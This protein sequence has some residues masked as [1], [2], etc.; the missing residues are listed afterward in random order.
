[1]RMSDFDNWSCWS[2][3]GA[4]TFK[5][6]Q[7]TNTPNDQYPLRKKRGA[8]TAPQRVHFLVHRT[9]PS[10]PKRSR[11]L[12]VPIC[13]IP[14]IEIPC[15]IDQEN[16]AQLHE[17][18][19]WIF[20]PFFLSVGEEKCCILTRHCTFLSE[21]EC[22]PWFLGCNESNLSWVQVLKD[23]EQR[24]EAIHGKMCAKSGQFTS[25][26][27][28]IVSAWN[29]SPCSYKWIL[30]NLRTVS[31]NTDVNRFWGL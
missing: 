6:T 20:L 27:N 24:V 15:W 26:H 7:Q 12:S 17:P 13:I 23:C 22:F 30:V 5:V 29:S 9:D 31:K 14:P 1:M 2:L 8:K 3:A 19:Y 25:V 21:S 18:L 16:T 4:I 11:F 28:D 10:L